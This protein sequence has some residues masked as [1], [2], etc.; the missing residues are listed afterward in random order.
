MRPREIARLPEC[1][2]KYGIQDINY[3]GSKFT[4]DNKQPGEHRVVFASLTGQ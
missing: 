1:V 4:W 3:T 2:I